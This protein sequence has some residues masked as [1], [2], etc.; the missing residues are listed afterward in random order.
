M[1]KE[2]KLGTMKM[3][4]YRMAGARDNPGAIFEMQKNWVNLVQSIYPNA[5]SDADL[6]AKMIGRIYEVWQGYFWGLKG[7]MNHE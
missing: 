7:E 1:T 4:Y 3:T 6:D 2:Q 5:K